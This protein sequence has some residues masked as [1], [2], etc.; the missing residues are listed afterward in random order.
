MLGKIEGRRRRGQQRMRWLDG[1]TDL[2]NLTLTKLQELMMDGKVWCAA[3]H[4]ITKSQT[5]LRDWTELIV[6]SPT[7][8]EFSMIFDV[9]IAIKL[10]PWSHFLH[11]PKSPSCSIS[12]SHHWLL[13]TNYLLLINTVV[14]FLF[15]YNDLKL[16]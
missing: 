14:V 11:C 12:S 6:L 10:L 13:E 16:C 4:G 7:W 5:W 3:V 8:Y 1:I 15:L 9:F 2:M